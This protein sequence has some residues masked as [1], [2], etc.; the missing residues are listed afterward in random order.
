MKH[1]Y[2]LLCLLLIPAGLQAGNGRV[3]TALN[4]GWTVKPISNTTRN[5]P[6]TPVTLPHTWNAFYTL[7]E[8]G[9]NRETMVY[10]RALEVTPQMQDKRVFLY[11]EGV[12]SVADVFVN[13]RSAGHHKGGYTAFCLEI[14][15]LLRQGENELEVWAGNAFRSDVLPISGDFNVYGGIHRPVRL[16]VTEQNCISPLFY[17]SP[18]V[19]VHQ[20]SISAE[21]ACISVETILSLQGETTS[22]RLCTSV[23]DAG[24]NIVATQETDVTGERVMQPFNI[25]KPHLWNGKA[26]PYLYQVTARLVNETGETIDEVKQSTG[27]RSFHVDADK[28]FFLNGHAYDLHGFNRHEDF[29]GH[30]S[31]LTMEEYR[32]DMALVN[33]TGATML[34]LAHYPHGEPIYSLCDE[35][36]IIL[37]S[38]I[39]LCGPGGYK[40]TGYL[41]SVEENAWQAAHELVYQKFNHPSV[42]FWG[43][44]NELLVNDG[45]S[46]A[47]Y[48]NPVTFIKRLNGLYHEIDSSRLTTFATCVDQTAYLGCSDL[49][50]WNKYFGWNNVG[51]SA[52]AFFDQA[53]QTSNGRPVGVSEY[54]LGGSALQHADPLYYQTDHIPGTYH[55]EEYQAICHEGYWEALQA[56]PYLWTK[57]VW[58]FTDMQSSIKNEGDTPGINDKGMVTYDRQTLKDAFYFYK[59]NW[60]PDPMLH[61]CS[62]RYVDRVHANTSV[63]AYTNIDKVVLYVNDKKVGSQKPDAL[64]RIVW[65]NIVLQPGDNSIR[66]EAEKNGKTWTDSATWILTDPI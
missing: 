34:R 31:A 57:I 41:K 33:E 60:N 19:L 46:F 58:Q 13:R 16:I 53:R 11:F 56:R 47:E 25:H 15:S 51:Q 2:L 36:G 39:P 45:E 7:G 54:G 52:A 12:N 49:I 14:T 23:A 43:L 65:D 62:K 66:I 63:K 61:L 4:D 28:G 1:A 3:E 38:E 42:C 21:S 40:Y 30:G 24:G 18:G 17:A 32:Q 5:A 55:P 59:A 29:K 20:D 35:Q 9:Y 22:L 50:A 10:Q 8:K 27:F 64:K 44:F 37:W 48:D 26:D 6:T